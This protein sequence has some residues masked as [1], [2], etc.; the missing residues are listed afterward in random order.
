MS[1]TES[2]EKAIEELHKINKK[3]TCFVTTTED[4]A[5][6]RAN[7]LTISKKKGALHGIIISVKDNICTK[8]IKTTAGSAILSNYV[9]TYNATVIERIEQEGGIIIGKTTMDDFGFGTFN[10]NV[11]EGIPIPKNPHDISRSSGGSSGGSGAATAAFSSNSTVAERLAPTHLSLSESTGGSITSPAAF[12]GV[13]GFTPSYGRVSR[14]GLI[15]YANSLDKIGTM[16]KTVSE[17]EQLARVIFGKDAKDE[18]S[19]VVQEKPAKKVKKVAI[20]KEMLQGVDEKILTA[21]W[22]S[23]ELTGIPYEE[24][25]LPSLEY[26]VASYYIIATAEAS[27]NLSRYTGLRYGAQE[28]FSG[29]FN[30]YF[31]SIRSKYFSAEEKRRIILGTFVRTAGYKDKYYLK[32][33]KIREKIN[34]DFHILFKKYDALLSP[35]MPIIAPKFDEI[36]KLKPI[37]IYALDSCTIP[38]NLA[39]LP[40]LSIPIGKVNSMPVGLQVICDSLDENTLFEFGK[41]IESLVKYK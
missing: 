29:S 8:G 16:G 10:V 18:T 6:K 30:D 33:L 12:C 17:A 22:K 23:I 2:T 1:V 4:Y 14:Y 7:E 38:P 39:L 24:I 26:A 15:D 36:S 25:S 5:R 31:S 35:S 27:S 9:P 11:G 20:I 28:E 34:H 41:Q 19:L 21:F 37:E 3:Y 32:A 13:V 40:H